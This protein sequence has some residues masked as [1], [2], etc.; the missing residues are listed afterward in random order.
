MAMQLSERQQILFERLVTLGEWATKGELP[1][2]VLEIRGFGSFFRGKPRPSDVDLILRVQRPDHL[3]E[4]DRFI[5]LVKSVRYDWKLEKRF[6]TPQEALDRLRSNGD[7]RCTEATDDEYRKFLNWI[8]PYSWN[9]LRPDT[10][11]KECSF[12]APEDYAKR[13]VKRQLPNLNIVMFQNPDD[14]E[15]RPVGLRCGFTV[16]LWSTKFTDTAANLNSLLAEQTVVDNLQQE[17]AYFNVQIPKVEAQASLYDAEIELLSRI[18]RRR[19]QISSSWN[20]LE[21]FSKGHTSLKAF[22][23]QLEK[24]EKAADR[25][26]KEEWGRHPQS[27]VASLAQTAQKAD[28]ARKKLKQL[29]QRNDLLE[30]LRNRLAYF[31][32]GCAKS[33]LPAKEY[34]VNDLLSEGSQKKKEQMADF[35]RTLGYPVDRVLQRNERELLQRRRRVAEWFPHTDESHSED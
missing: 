5:T 9:M 16:L 6:P 4:F 22:Q 3:P 32:S 17:M 7:K 19:K 21:S 31:K 1:S 12:E 29:Y 13:M 24:A 28:E 35:L 26:D 20:W 2:Q 10:I 27:D 34:V 14:T 8:E 15:I 25:F 30:A 11:H 18:P 33:D 23:E